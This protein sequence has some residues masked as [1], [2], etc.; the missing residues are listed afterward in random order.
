MLAGSTRFHR[1]LATAA[2]LA[3]A[4]GAQATRA[5]SEL[6]FSAQWTDRIEATFF[7]RGRVSPEKVATY[8]SAL[9]SRRQQILSIYEA[10]YRDRGRSAASARKRAR[11]KKP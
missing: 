6:P 1:L 2:L 11:R 5:E 9:A 8:R 7:D 10:D 3:V 4:L